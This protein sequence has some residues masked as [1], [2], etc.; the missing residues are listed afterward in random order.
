M[1]VY[2]VI[3]IYEDNGQTYVCKV[4]G[5]VD[6]YDA[7]RM[8]ATKPDFADDLCIVGAIEG[9]HVLITPGEDNGF[10]AYASD[11]QLEEN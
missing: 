1:K 9:D 7:M 10:C 3:G 6:A 2:T 8:A 11:L 4:E 5:A